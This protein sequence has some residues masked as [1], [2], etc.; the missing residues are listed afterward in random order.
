MLKERLSL[1]FADRGFTL[2]LV[3]R[4]QSMQMQEFFHTFQY[5][6][7]TYSI[8][9]DFNYGITNVLGSKLLDIF[10]DYIQMVNKPTL[11]SA[12]LIGR[13]YI[14][15]RLIEELL[16]NATVE[17]IYF[18]DHCKNTVRILTGKNAVD[19]RTIPSD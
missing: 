8:A 12:S 16:T 13:V 9:G 19:F 2:M 10:T 4:K 7:A 11:I 15:K 18:S 17:N 1:A 5:L 6:V 3:Y 14:K